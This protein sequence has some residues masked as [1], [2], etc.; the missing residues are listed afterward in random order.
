MRKLTQKETQH[1]RR[2][3]RVLETAKR[4]LLKLATDASETQLFPNTTLKAYTEVSDVL[5]R[6]ETRIIA[7]DARAI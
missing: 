1:T 2:V 4:A 3:L 5:H 6:T 7:R